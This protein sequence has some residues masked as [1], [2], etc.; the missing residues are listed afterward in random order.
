MD[1][2]RMLHGRTAYTITKEGER[3]LEGA[4]IE[5]DELRSRRR[6]LTQELNIKDISE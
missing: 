5:W 1:N 3:F 6:V 2:T 4:Y